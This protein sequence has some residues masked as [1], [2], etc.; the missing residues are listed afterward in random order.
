MVGSEV[1]FLQFSI[2]NLSR[3]AIAL[4]SLP[5]VVSASVSCPT[6]CTTIAPSGDLGSDEAS[7]LIEVFAKVAVAP[8]VTPSATWLIDEAELSCFLTSV[9][10]LF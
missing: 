9:L 5:N 1:I 2:K 6:S 10:Q 3:P 4:T 7:G 8:S